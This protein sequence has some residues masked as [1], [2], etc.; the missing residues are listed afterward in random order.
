MEPP[1]KCTLNMQNCIKNEN[2]ESPLL[3]S[4]YFMKRINLIFASQN[5]ETKN[6]GGN[7]KEE[8]EVYLSRMCFLSYRSSS[9]SAPAVAR[10]RISTPTGMTISL[11]LYKGK[12]HTFSEMKHTIELS[13]ERHAVV[14]NARRLHFSLAVKCLSVPLVRKKPFSKCLSRESY[15]KLFM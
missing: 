7:I 2:S 8:R 9:A 6:H 10:Q 15:E 11:K 4:K 5:Y 12:A 13:S 3:N 14:R 1:G